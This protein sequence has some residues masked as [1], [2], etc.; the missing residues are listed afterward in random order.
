[1]TSTILRPTSTIVTQ[2]NGDHLD[3]DDNVI[4]PAAGDGMGIVADGDDEDAGKFII[5]GLTPPII[6][7]LT[8]FTLNINAKMDDGDG[9]DTRQLIFQFLI[10]G[11]IHSS[12]AFLPDDNTFSWRTKVVT[13]QSYTNLELSQA[14]LKFQIDAGLDKDEQ[15]TV[16]VFY[17]DITHTDPVV[18]LQGGKFRGGIYANA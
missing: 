17:I 13:G 2:L 14:T 4:N 6:D 15:L 3:I 16:D 11:D 18:K 7:T 9:N 8:D 1:M 12:T 5:L 10:G